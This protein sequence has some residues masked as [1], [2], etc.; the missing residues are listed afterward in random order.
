[1]NE[2]K[3]HNYAEFDIEAIYERAEGNGRIFQFGILKT[4]VHGYEE[5]THALRIKTPVKDV[6]F[7][8]NASDAG[9]I[10]LVAYVLNGDKNV[11]EH[12]ITR[13]LAEID[14]LGDLIERSNKE[15]VNHLTGYRLNDTD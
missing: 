8:L 5:E 9:W 12:W 11:N 15:G 7:L 1:M 4:P 3:Q 13:R 10:G 2:V 6:T 14:F